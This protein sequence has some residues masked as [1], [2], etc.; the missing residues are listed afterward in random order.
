[1]TP[2]SAAPANVTSATALG[3]VRTDVISKTLPDA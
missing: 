3:T 1:M 2:L